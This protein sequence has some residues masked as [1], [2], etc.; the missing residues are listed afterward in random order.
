LRADLRE[1]AAGGWNEIK[2]ITDVALLDIFEIGIHFGDLRA[3]EKDE[4]I[5]SIGITRNGEEIERCP[6]RGYI[7]L[8]V[9]TPDFEAMMWY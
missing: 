6:W 7:A 2:D 9:P 4:V 1:K 3:R 5:F 8:T